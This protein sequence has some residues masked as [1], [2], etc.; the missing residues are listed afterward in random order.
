MLEGFEPAT[1]DVF[2]SFCTLIPRNDMPEGLSPDCQNVVFI[3][4]GVG[5][6]PGFISRNC[7]S[8]SSYIFTS[9][10]Q[11]VDESGTRHRL[12][13]DANGTLSRETNGTLTTVG[14]SLGLGMSMKACQFGT[15]LYMA[16][17][18]GK[19]ATAQPRAYNLL[20]SV[21]YLDPVSAEGSVTGPVFAQ[22][23]GMGTAD[24]GFRYVLYVRE[25]RSGYLTSPS[26][27]GGPIYTTPNY[28]WDF[29][30][31]NADPNSAYVTRR[32]IYVSLG[33]GTAASAL[34]IYYTHPTLW[35]ENN[36]ATSLTGVAM[37]DAALM[38]FAGT[39][40]SGTIVSSGIRPLPQSVGLASYSNRLV[41]WGVSH[42]IPFISQ[43]LASLGITS[44]IANLSFDGGCRPTT[45]TV[46]D[47]WSWLA[48]AG[49]CVWTNTVPGSSGMAMKFIGD[50]TTR[51][52]E[53]VGD[54]R[55]MARQELSPS[56]SYYARF[57]AKRSAGAAAGNLTVV[58][59]SGGLT[60]TTPTSSITTDWA[61]YSGPLFVSGSLGSVS[62]SHIQ[63]SWPSGDVGEWVAIDAL[64]VYPKEYAQD[65][66]ILYVS[67]FADPET[68]LYGSQVSVNEN[69]GERITNCYE[70]RG[71]LRVSKERSLYSVVDTATSAG[72]WHVERASDTIGALGPWAVGQGDGWAILA[73]YDGIYMDTGG[74]PDKI[75]QEINNTWA[76]L[77]RDYAY[78]TKVAVDTDSRR[79]FVLY[80]SGTST[81]TNS[82]LVCDYVEGWE[83]STK[84]GGRGRKWCPWTYPLGQIRDIAFLMS[85]DGSPR[86]M[87]AGTYS[88]KGNLMSV[89]TAAV[90]P[91]PAR[92]YQECGLTS[93][94]LSSSTGLTSS[95]PYKFKV[96]V[97]GRTAVQST[98]TPGAD[99]T[100][101]AVLALMNAQMTGVL[102]GVTW[103]IV[104]GDLRCTSPVFGTGSSISLSF[105]DD[106]DLFGNLTGFTAF[107]TGAA[108]V[109]AAPAD[110]L[111]GTSY[112]V[113]DAYYE[114]ATIGMPQ[115]RSLFGY[116]ILRTNG[117][118]EIN[119]SLVSSDGSQLPMPGNPLSANP[120]HDVEIPIQKTGIQ[121]GIRFGT[122]G[123]NDTFFLRRVSIFKKPAPFSR[124][125]G[126]NK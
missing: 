27:T 50:G 100:Y 97:N 76:N 39:D 124:V 63:I 42:A 7:Q 92:G 53:N 65:D 24:G 8:S 45:P 75:S 84:T 102:A 61:W 93:K 70:I 107:E 69:D 64:Q 82:M 72:D 52:L 67:E 87:L 23:S 2:G 117:A 114:T 13:L 31:V 78:L 109:G 15:R 49:S 30:N 4:G 112:G 33:A 77:N 94:T 36:T 54:L 11:Y 62:A 41:A 115:G 35:I 105:G 55:G 74:V 79:V 19:I 108:G 40:N 51:T 18:D 16:F 60:I 21:D 44:P 83:D 5:S 81:Y 73:S 106:P 104:G 68:F 38:G 86:V 56:G 122:K 99:L 1:V 22:A 32:R 125:R 111:D 43:P 119:V 25:T 126:H 37:T 88:S 120:I 89:D 20:D 98:I 116:V 9:L 48:G 47:G 110:Y 85:D 96:S 95:V 46:P 6:R 103:A 34:P 14:S 91:Q 12:V 123:L 80:P 3:P 113:I 90:S 66:S 101:G 26:G 118:G 29:S 59:T 58:A 121:F 57:R 28:L 17:S 71:V 10:A